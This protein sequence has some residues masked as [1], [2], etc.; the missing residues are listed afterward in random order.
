MKCY[1]EQIQKLGFDSGDHTV[2][3]IRC[4]RFIDRNRFGRSIYNIKLK[5]CCRCCNEE[6]H[7]Q[8]KDWIEDL[9]RMREQEKNEQLDDVE[10]MNQ[11]H[12]GSRHVS[13]RTSWL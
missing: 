12:A 7:M 13:T 8:D 2:L 10:E 3:C 4:L 6:K 1:N 9:E 11:D 5:I